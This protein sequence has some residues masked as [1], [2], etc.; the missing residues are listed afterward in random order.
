VEKVIAGKIELSSFL[1]LGPGSDASSS[2][3]MVMQSFDKERLNEEGINNK[4]TGRE[5]P[6]GVIR[7]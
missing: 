4:I 1:S 5:N 7:H 3:R 6:E 2:H